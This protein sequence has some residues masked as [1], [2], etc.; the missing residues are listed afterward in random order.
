MNNFDW[1]NDELIS[2]YQR[3]KYDIINIENGD[4]VETLDTIED[5]REFINIHPNAENLSILQVNGNDV[6]FVD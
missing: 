4:L 3:V 1:D 2:P 5:A 6:S